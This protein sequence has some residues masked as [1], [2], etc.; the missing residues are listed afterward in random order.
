MSICFHFGEGKIPNGR[1]ATSYA[2]CI[3]NFLR[4]CL[5]GGAWVGQ[6]VKCLT[7][8]F[9][10]GHDLRVMRLSPA[11]DCTLSRESA[12]PSLSPSVLT[13]ALSLFLK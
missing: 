13:L 4:N 3:F 11:L 10:S 2:K 12:S 5:P 9:G 1:I 6:L 8:D 7:L